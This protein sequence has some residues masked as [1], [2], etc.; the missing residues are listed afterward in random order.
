MVMFF[1]FSEFKIMIILSWE[2]VMG[3][4]EGIGKEVMG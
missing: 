2:E 3:V 1:I 4:M